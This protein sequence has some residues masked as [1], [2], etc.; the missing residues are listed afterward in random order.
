MSNQEKYN[1]WYNYNTW[2]VALWIGKDEGLYSIAKEIAER[3]QLNTYP[4]PY[5]A[6]IEYMR[7]LESTETPD[8]V[9][10]ND[11]GLDYDELDGMMMEM[12]QENN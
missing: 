5:K 8:G 4:E 7:E 12:V 9:A 11:S 3:E 2:N 1:G 10:W 6:F